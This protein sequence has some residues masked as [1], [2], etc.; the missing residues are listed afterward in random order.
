VVF[1]SSDF[2]SD[3]NVRNAPE[4]LSAALNAVDWLAQDESLITIR[5]KDRTPPPLVFSSDLV[6]DGVKYA[7][8]IGVPVVLVAFAG[9]RLWR[10]RQLAR[11]PY[12]VSEPVAEVA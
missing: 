6:R 3:R 1:G 9:V 7:N 11:R 4:N 10:R 2:A 12:R 5:A 8:L